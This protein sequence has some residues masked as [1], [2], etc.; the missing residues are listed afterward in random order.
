MEE[1]EEGK[2]IF[3]EEPG[4]CNSTTKNTLTYRWKIFYLKKDRRGYLLMVR[5][6]AKHGVS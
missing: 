1:E 6:F 5:K 2:S 4:I 3:F